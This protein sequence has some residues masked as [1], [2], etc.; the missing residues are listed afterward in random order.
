MTV[1]SLDFLRETPYTKE[2]NCIGQ[3]VVAAFR[4]R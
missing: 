1:C 2:H 4:K 3:P